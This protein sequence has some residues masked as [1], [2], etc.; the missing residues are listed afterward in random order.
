MG[1]KVWVSSI[2]FCWEKINRNCF[3]STR[4]PTLSPQTDAPILFNIMATNHCFN[5]QTKRKKTDQTLKWYHILETS[6]FH[7]CNMLLGH[8]GGKNTE[9]NSKDSIEEEITNDLTHYLLLIWHLNAAYCA[10]NNFYYGIDSFSTVSYG[11]IHFSLT[12]AQE[13]WLHTIAIADISAL[14]SYC[15]R[16]DHLHCIC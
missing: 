14:F 9:N 15:S 7:V 11:F 2:I 1:L 4:K 12:G 10:I 13:D 6:Y 3:Y 8:R 16:N 5:S